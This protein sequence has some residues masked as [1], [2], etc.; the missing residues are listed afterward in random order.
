MF[1]CKILIRS[2]DYVYFVALDYFI[3][4]FQDAFNC[5]V[6]TEHQSKEDEDLTLNKSQIRDVFS[7]LHSKAE[8]DYI[9]KMKDINAGEFL[10]V[11]GLNS[12]V[13]TKDDD[14]YDKE[15]VLSNEE[16][17]VKSEGFLEDDEV[18]LSGGNGSED[19]PDLAQVGSDFVVG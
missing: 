12:L 8:N 13:N 16:L 5:S 3:S 4:I 11:C 2:I 7:E 14:A 19:G 6:A 9:T 1:F 10:K 17:V 15:E 18:S